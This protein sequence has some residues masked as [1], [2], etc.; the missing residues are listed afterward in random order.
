MVHVLLSVRLCTDKQI[1]ATFQTLVTFGYGVKYTLHVLLGR[2]DFLNQ[3]KSKGGNL[4][5]F[6]QYL[7][8]KYITHFTF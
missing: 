5:L 1:T 8:S 2:R 4:C 7:Q 3:K 6:L